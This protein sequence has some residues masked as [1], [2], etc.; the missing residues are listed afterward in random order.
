MPRITMRALKSLL[1]ATALVAAALP[2][3]AKILGSVDFTLLEPVACRNLDDAIEAS[4]FND[5]NIAKSDRW[6]PQVDFVK[7]HQASSK[8]DYPYSGIASNVPRRIPGK[9][10]CVIGTEDVRGRMPLAQSLNT[11][12][13]VKWNAPNLPAGMIAIC[14]VNF[15]IG[16]R[17]RETDCTGTAEF[18]DTDDA[19]AFGYWVVT[20]PE[21]FMRNFDLPKGN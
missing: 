12:V 10:D 9:G 14:A 20:K 13:Q 19:V 5:F 8:V 16:G 11:A 4:K 6:L 21:N 1:V 2:A 3:K 18:A 15:G 17:F 7:R